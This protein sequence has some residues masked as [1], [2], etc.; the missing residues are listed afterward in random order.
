MRK[1][2]H[3][4]IYSILVLAVSQFGFADVNAQI[5]A[6]DPTLVAWWK[7]DEGAGTEISDSSRYE[8]DS[9]LASTTL[10]WTDGRINGALQ[11]NGASDYVEF[12]RS[13]SLNIRDALAVTL[14]VRTANVGNGANE[15]LVLKGEF[16]YGLRFT[17]ANNLE[18]RIFSTGYQSIETPVTEAF[19]D[20]WHHLAGV[21]DGSALM[22]YVDGELMASTASSGTINRDDNYYVNLGRN[23]QGD[24]NNRWWYSGAMDDVR[25]YS[26]ALSQE[27]IRK[28]LRPEYSSMPTPVDGAADVWPD[29]ALGWTPGIAAATHDVYLGIVLEDVN[30]ASR[31]NP[32]GVLVSQNQDAVTYDPPGR[33]AYDATY[34][35]RVDEVSPA[36]DNTI[37]KGDIWSFTVPFAFPIEQVTA[38]ASSS[39]KSNT[40]PENTVNGSGLDENDLHGTNAET[41]W[42]SAKGEPAWI[43]YEFDRL[44]KLHQMLV[45][46]YNVQVER[47]VGFGFK[48]VTV[49]Y[50]MDG[51]NWTALGDFEFSQG[52]SQAGYAANT[53]L[54]FGDVVARHVRLTAKSNFSGRNQYGLSEVRFLA[55][56]THAWEPQPASGQT[57]VTRDVTLAW[58][59]GREAASHEVYVSADEQSVI[60]GTALIDVVTASQYMPGTLDLGT[61]YYWKVNEVNE[62]ENPS[63]WEGAIWDFTTAPYLIVDD[64][65][66]Y[67]DDDAAGE[68]IWQTWLDGY[69]D[70]TNGAL[71]GNATPPYAEQTIVYSGDQ[72]MPV[73]YDNTG[74]TSSVAVRTFETPQDWATGGATILTVYFRGVTTNNADEPLWVRLTDQAGSQGTVTYG[75]AAD[76]DAANQAAAAWARWDVPLADFGVN[77][78]Q[79]KAL[80]LGF[81]AGGGTPPRSTGLMYFDDIR[82]GKPVSVE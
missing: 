47:V 52:P 46:N 17:N 45:W 57:N 69:E 33:L 72:S 77:L 43:Q 66:S 30:N 25:I 51:E 36:P 40:G 56:P 59:A 24:S 55:I 61:T 75:L 60:D 81:G 58:R 37:Y 74:A 27:E 7:L 63:A 41:M 71:V 13:E 2:S 39:N 79:I 6:A 78:T 44:Y 48:E 64:F 49:E 16:T 1:R 8:N 62:A 15:A 20:V 68:A 4:L 67:T 65:E 18:F 28:M 12:G 19:N 23:S 82:I 53:A 70:P 42:L 14:W 35:W 21:Y 32:L 31:A 76:E 50:S 38:T 5:G 26:R 80:A 10:A 54:E 22:L 29:A 11:F 73:S 3:Y 9:N 34:Y